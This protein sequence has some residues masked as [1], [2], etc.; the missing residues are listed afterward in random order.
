[1]KRPERKRTMGSWNETCMLSGLPIM[2]GDGCTAVL[3]L[4]AP[5]YHNGCYACGEYLPVFLIKGTYDGYGRILPD[6]GPETKALLRHLCMQGIYGIN[7]ERENGAVFTDYHPG[8]DKVLRM[9][10][11]HKDV[12]AMAAENMETDALR[13][14]QLIFF[15]GL[16]R[17]AAANADLQEQKDSAEEIRTE[18]RK[19]Q[20]LTEA[21]NS[22]CDNV[23]SHVRNDIVW[24]LL[25]VDPYATEKMLLRIGR[26]NALLADLRRAWHIPSGSG[27]QESTEPAQRLFLRFYEKALDGLEES[28]RI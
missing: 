6:D 12:P 4:K 14:A 28:L 5:Y 8:S 17:E 27:S 26:L 25:A 2:E 19:R 9:V 23:P 11:L 18:C 3:L 21:L 7:E 1:M 10:F 13:Q 20:Q 24:E 22:L 15:A 16:C